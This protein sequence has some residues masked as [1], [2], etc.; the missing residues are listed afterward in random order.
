MFGLFKGLHMVKSYVND[1]R[2]DNECNNI[3]ILLHWRID[4]S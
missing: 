3:V 4:Y 1:N 2:N